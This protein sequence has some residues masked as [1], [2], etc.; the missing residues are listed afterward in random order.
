MASK[1]EEPEQ[2]ELSVDTPIEKKKTKTE[3][4]PIE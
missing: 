4:K 3:I 2:S 1:I